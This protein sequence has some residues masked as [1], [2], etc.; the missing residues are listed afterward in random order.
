MKKFFIIVLYYVV[1]NMLT[2][3]PL[4][5]LSSNLWKHNIIIISFFSILW[6]LI[7][8]IYPKLKARAEDHQAIFAL[9]ISLKFLASLVFISIMY[10]KNFFI[11]TF[12]LLIFMLFY[13]VY[14]FLMIYYR[15]IQK[16]IK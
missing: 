15:N 9:H 7:S 3:L 8:F 1:L 4:F 11:N 10:Y 13:F 5:F 2:S 16:L 14:S 12:S 6:L